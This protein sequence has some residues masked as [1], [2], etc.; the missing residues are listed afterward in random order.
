MKDEINKLVLD[1]FKLLR[2]GCE[3]KGEDIINFKTKYTGIV[4][5]LFKDVEGHKFKHFFSKKFVNDNFNEDD[6]N[7][8]TLKEYI[9]Y[10]LKMD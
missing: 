6:F 8:I 10:N 1:Y 3:V 9:V 7:E 4:E 2:A 5:N